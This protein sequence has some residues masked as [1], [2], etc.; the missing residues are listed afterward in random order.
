[1]DKRQPLRILAAGLLLL[2][3]T[4]CANLKNYYPC[5]ASTTDGDITDSVYRMISFD[6]GLADLNIDVTTYRRTV[7]LKG[8][9]N[10]PEQAK[11]LFKLAKN[12][13][14]VQKVR[15]QLSLRCKKS[16]NW[17]KPITRHDHEP[18]YCFEY[19]DNGK[20]R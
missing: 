5:E 1:M 12:V 10:N 4:S 9:V 16:I 17:A 15:S 13:Y 18:P 19:S 6:R 3:T 20:H 14:C 2:F 7:T 11:A 8:N